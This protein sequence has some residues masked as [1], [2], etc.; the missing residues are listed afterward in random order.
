MTSET[1]YFLPINQEK[2]AEES[3]SPAQGQE[4]EGLVCVGAEHCMEELGSVP[5]CPAWG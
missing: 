4:M 1:L 5:L 2:Q 3:L